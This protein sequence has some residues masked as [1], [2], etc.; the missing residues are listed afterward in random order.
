MIGRVR[1]LPRPTTKDRSKLALSAVMRDTS[2]DSPPLPGTT[3][4]PEPHA[5]VI[6][7]PQVAPKYSPTFADRFI[8]LR[9][10]LLAIWRARNW[11][12]LTERNHADRF[13]DAARRWS[14]EKCAVLPVLAVSPRIQRNGDA[15]V[16]PSYT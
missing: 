5:T 10:S 3:L 1:A 4:A 13:V 15:Y 16:F 7:S 6:W 14:I 11:P 2:A 8:P 12:E 9:L